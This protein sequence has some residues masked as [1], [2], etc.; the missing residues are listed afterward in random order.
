MVRHLAMRARR[1]IQ[2][3]LFR[4][5]VPPVRRWLRARWEGPEDTP[6]TGLVRFGDLRR[7]E[8]IA[9]SRGAHASD[10]IDRHYARAYLERHHSDIRGRVLAMAG[11]G[12]AME[13]GGDRVMRVD[14]VERQHRGEPD[15]TFVCDLA[16][17]SDLPSE[18][19]DCVVLTQALH[20]VFDVREAVATIHRILRPGGVALVTM[21][22]ITPVPDPEM[23]PS[24]AP[25]W[26]LTAL[27]A[28]RLFEEHFERDAVEVETFGNVLVAASFLH[29]LQRTELT[30]E[31]LGHRDPDYEV[32]I[33]VRARKGGG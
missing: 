15:T 9:P 2:A 12:D 5:S 22:G 11:D 4:A 19:F 32:L 31:E 16:G 6:P 33:A 1:L 7:L 24:A 8:P 26:S 10:T 21:P 23:Q 17:S 3:L 27:S 13:L 14:R 30:L 29:G 25:A 20:L 28:R 18:A